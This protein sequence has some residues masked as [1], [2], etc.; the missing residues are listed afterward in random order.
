VRSRIPDVGTLVNDR[1]APIVLK[2]SAAELFE[3]V[4]GETGAR[5]FVGAQAGIGAGSGN[6]KTAWKVQTQFELVS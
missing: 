1:F 4:R 5:E 6:R 3:M 2:K